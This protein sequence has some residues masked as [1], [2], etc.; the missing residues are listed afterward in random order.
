MPAQSAIFAV[1]SRTAATADELHVDAADCGRLLELLGLVP[2]P[3]KRRG[4]RHS[5]VAVLAIAAAAV[6]RSKTRC[7]SVTCGFVERIR[8]LGGIR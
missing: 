2:D 6:Y 1:L 5:V 4:V 3:R 8:S 7:R